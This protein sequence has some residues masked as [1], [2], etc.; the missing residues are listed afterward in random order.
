LNPYET[1]VVSK[2]ASLSE[3]KKTYRK[4]SK[5]H[6]PDMGGSSEEMA[7]VARAYEILSDP[8]KRKRWDETGSDKEPDIAG[9]VAV[10]FA[11]MVDKIFFQPGVEM[12]AKRAIDTFS[13]VVERE[14]NSVNVQIEQQRGVLNRAKARIKKAPERD[15]M[16]GMID[17]NLLQLKN[18]EAANDKNR[19]VHR[20]AL[21]LIRSYV[22]REPAEAPVYGA[23][24]QPGSIAD[25][26]Q[27]LGFTR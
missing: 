22:F 15:L 24:V 4:L 26:I 3:I 21:K 1:L 14:Y 13:E 16:G 6:H 10:A 2:D 11:T 25:Q 17:Q 23:R 12:S 5:Q 8:E 27:R 18:S 7:K 20:E 9:E 19:D